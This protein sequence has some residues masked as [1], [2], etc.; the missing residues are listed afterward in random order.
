M[1]REMIVFRNYLKVA[2]RNLTKTR[3]FSAVNILGL[4]IGMTA[5]LMILHYVNFERSFDTFHEDYDRVYRLRYERTDDAGETVKFASCCPPAAARIRG[6]YPE[7]EQ[8]ARIFHYQASVSHGADK[9][10]EERVYFAEPEFASILQFNYL[11]GDPAVDLQEPGRAFVSESIARKYFGD[12]DP[13]GQTL[14]MNGKD[15]YEIV[16]LFEDPSANSHLKFDFLLPWKNL[17]TKLGADYTEAWGHTGSYTY[18]KAAPGTDPTAFEE[19][20][21]PMIQ[22]EC[23]WLDE[24][25]MA[26]DLRM[27]PLADIHLTSHY[28]QEYEANGNADSV[29]ILFIIAFFII[30]M[31]WVNFVNLSTATSINRAKEV[32][33]RKVVGASRKQLI[34]QFFLEIILTNVIAMAVALSA[35]SAAL[36]AFNGFTGIPVD[37]PLFSQNWFW[38]AVSGMFTAGVILS[39]LY[40]V[41]ALSSFKPVS[42]LK[43]RISNSA[44]GVRLRQGLVVFQFAVGVV[45]VIATLT[46]FRQISY[47]RSQQLGFSMDQTL[48]VKAPR[49][50]GENY[51]STLESFRETVRQS[52]EVDKM[53]HVTEVPGRQIYWDAGGIHKAGDDVTQG[54]NYQIV[55]VDYE[56]ADVF[57]LEIVAGRFFSKDHPSDQGALMLNETAIKH[58][59]FENPESAVGQQVSYWGELYP[60]IG[61]L[62]DYHQQSLR[63]AFE[64]HI[65]RYMP[66]GRGAMGAM[67]IKI[68][69]GD[70]QAMVAS[71][72][73]QYDAFWPGNSFDYFFLDDYFN[74]QYEADELFGRVYSLFSVLAIIIVVLGIYGLSSFSVAQ[75]TK[76]IG[77]RKV[78][79]ASVASIMG[80]LTKEFV[81]LVVLANVVAWPVAWYAMTRWLEGFAFRT[82][83]G[84]LTFAVAGISTLVVALLTIG[85]QVTRAA[86]ANPVDAIQHE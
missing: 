53:C 43:S 2:F 30:L 25:S 81:M 21:Q 13:I 4:A 66:E 65:F 16:G 42:V 33:L 60:V 84:V 31:A 6:N 72:K 47:M 29:E 44:R 82:D 63:Q 75:L 36:P 34:A 40:P 19:K 15:D 70:M 71:V 64:P 8:I 51:G 59:G 39:G 62:K 12:Q 50:R 9:F 83:I 37:F 5:C 22:A 77:I 14:T 1:Q 28:M 78:L 7:V 41:A 49:V 35:I 55:G 56:F 79:G 32:G 23:P 24:Y 69:S 46:V 26:I 85:Y 61:V 3:L 27:Q 17:E 80:L 48:V 52:A 10:L 74:Q 73:E 58:M 11:H 86:N 45:L 54:K 67:A 38:L 20:L 18:V 68:N 57:D 76:Q